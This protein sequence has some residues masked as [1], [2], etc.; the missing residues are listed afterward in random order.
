MRVLAHIQGIC[1]FCLLSAVAQAGTLDKIVKVALDSGIASPDPYT[2]LSEEALGYSHL[3]FDPLLRWNRKMELEPRLAERWERT[4]PTTVRFYLRRGVKFH[5]GNTM[6]A[7][8]VLWSLDHLKN[9]PE[10]KGLFE[11]FAPA[12]AVDE[13]T[14]DIITHKPYGLTVNLAAYIFV[15]D[16]KFYANPSRPRGKPS[17]TGPFQLEHFQL[18]AE[19][20]LRAFPGYWGPR[21]TVG[22]LRLLTMKDDS[23]RV[24]A[25]LSGVVDMILSVPVQDYDR[26]ENHRLV[27]FAS[28]DDLRLI[29]IQMNSKR[30][31]ELADP[32]VREAIIRATDNEYIV[33]RIMNGRATPATQQPFP[34]MEGHN[35]DLKPRYNL[36]RARPLLREAGHA[37]GLALTMISPDNH[38]VNDEKIA[39]AFVRMMSRAGITV[40]LETMPYTRYAD[41]FM[42]KSADLQLIG[43]RPDTGDAG[44]FSE[45]LLMCPDWKTGYGRYNSG[46]YCNRRLDALVLASQSEID[47]ERRAA[48][49]REIE[50]IAYDDAA[51]V[52]LHFE[53]YSWATNLR[54]K[55][56]EEIAGF[57]N[58]PYFGDLIAE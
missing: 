49:L 2:Q 12:E 6:T 54:L 5:S 1:L 13:Y 45:Y 44:N 55:N 41:E 31:K 34:H 28:S 51:F 32:R 21:G 35:P 4:S 50:R 15:M 17:G 53:Q 24:S 11:P 19:L 22:V 38:Y 3:I 58:W 27:R 29:T 47:Q 25:F 43:W 52:P 26:L 30:R 57:M 37:R 36:N 7:A 8:D 33:K 23:T 46:N 20:I 40:T 48:M 16:S 9:S 42:A 39:Q 14:V 56:L 10:Y 18:D